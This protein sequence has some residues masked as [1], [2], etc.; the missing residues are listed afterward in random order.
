MFGI[1]NTNSLSGLKKLINKE[2]SFLVKLS[3]YYPIKQELFRDILELRKNKNKLSL[4]MRQIKNVVRKFEYEDSKILRSFEN[5][6]DALVN[7]HIQSQSENNEAL[8]KEIE[9]LKKDFRYDREFYM[10]LEEVLYNQYSIFSKNKE[11][12]LTDSED[13]RNFIKFLEEE[14]NLLN[15]QVDEETRFKIEQDL[16]I[17]LQHYKIADIETDF[18]DIT[19]T[20]ETISGISIKTYFKNCL[21]GIGIVVV[22]GFGGFKDGHD[23]FS[24]RLALLGYPV[25]SF[26][27]PF[28]GETQYP[29][30]T[31]GILSEI[32]LMVVS[33]LKSKF[34]CKKIGTV[35]HSYGGIGAI[36]ASFKYTY[37]IEKTFYTVYEKYIQ[38][39]KQMLVPEVDKTAE[40]NEV[41]IGQ[42]N[43]EI[44]LNFEKNLV[45]IVQNAI[46]YSKYRDANIDFMVLV[47]TPTRIRNT[48]FSKNL[49]I[50]LSAILKNKKV[51]KKLRL[52]NALHADKGSSIFSYFIE[53]KN[54]IDYLDLIRRLAA[55]PTIAGDNSINSYMQKY[56]QSTP[57]LVIFG[58]KD[59]ITKAI[60]PYERNR[61]KKLFSDIGNCKT[62]T[63]FGS[64]SQAGHDFGYG[65]EKKKYGKEIF[66]DN[67]FN[68]VVFK[69]IKDQS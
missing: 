31:N 11:F 56:I 30:L 50:G 28:H 14:G 25:T 46:F 49:L 44:L 43:L 35:T 47:S 65:K 29:E 27:L 1:N 9:E 53:S 59:W 8:I 62:M 21:Y 57:K 37:E 5:M 18:K 54:F 68:R 19:I 32:I 45:N 51:V 2:K 40:E 38:T 64:F 24:K 39:I 26:D 20:S 34:G 67:K 13:L 55:H 16:L 33:N 60:N 6:R 41:F 10:Q 63:I 23:T 69:F 3:K 48:V 66:V 15:K 4:V 17:E 36:L 58:S 7:I 12:Y 22:H 61:M 42:K 52:I